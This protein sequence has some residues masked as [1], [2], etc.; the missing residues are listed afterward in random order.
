[1]APTVSSPR[2]AFVH[3]VSAAF[4][5]EAYLRRRARGGAPFSVKFP[6]LGEALFVA[7]PD[8]VRDIL[9]A[10]PTL[11]SPPVPNPIEP[12]LGPGS[13][14][15]LSGERHR[16]ER[17]LLM[18]AFHGDRMR[19][20]AG[21]MHEAAVAEM[22]DWRPGTRIAIREA[23]Q[24]I[25]LQIIIRAVFGIEESQRRAEYA[26]VITDLMGS[27]SAP[28]M[29]VPALRRSMAGLSPWDRFV[30]LRTRFDDLLT[31]QIAQRRKTVGQGHDDVLSL[32]LSATYDDGSSLS[33]DDLR[34]E[35]R[36]L[37]VAGHETTATSLA[38]AFYHIHNDE[39]VRERVVAELTG[40]PEPQEMAKLPYL[41]AVVQETLRMHP[42]VSIVLRQLRG[43]LSIQG[44]HRSAG[45]I[46]GIAVPALHFDPTL[47]PD[48]DR[49]DPARFL[50]R[51]PSP[52]AYTPFGGGHRR[53][54]GAAFACY[55]LAV[56]L[57]TVLSAV[58]LTRPADERRRRAPRSVPRG[59]TAVP[60]RDIVLEVVELRPRR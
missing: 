39:A 26:R 38:W 41:A 30:R 16:H 59:I 43:P 28:L 48:S 42:T 15:L 49:F 56:L 7:H 23:A 52:F 11:F 13:L 20:Y 31:T 37:L 47:W 45:D 34:H 6:G 54:V 25:T 4:D 10:P 60:N 50:D 36:T 22:A 18:P 17:L 32:L 29:L 9:T 46:V 35:L 5:P 2:F 53:C 33:D 1:M 58:T 44:V 51:K 24:A 12:L 14:I 57:G 55:E 40:N 3:A 21:V 27:Y 8:G 19:M